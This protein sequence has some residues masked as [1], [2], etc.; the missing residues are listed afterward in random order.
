M[1]GKTKCFYHRKWLLQ[2]YSWILFSKMKFFA[3]GVSG[4]VKWG[5]TGKW[6]ERAAKAQ[7]DIPKNDERLD[8]KVEQ[9]LG[10]TL[11]LHWH[12][13]F[14]SPLMVFAAHMRNAGHLHV[15]CC[16]SKAAG[17][18]DTWLKFLVHTKFS[19]LSVRST[20][21]VVRPHMWYH[22]L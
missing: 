16:F 10:L 5:S 19:V 12:S 11:L 4:R 21:Y 2:H 18:S 22:R 14:A 7:V 13:T 1:S 3:S 8:I 15:K 17:I 9:N 20:S 6:F